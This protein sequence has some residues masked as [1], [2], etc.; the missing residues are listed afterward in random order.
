MSAAVAGVTT[1]PLKP[2]KTVVD[3]REG[4]IPG[5][6]L[7]KD[8]TCHNVISYKPNVLKTVICQRNSETSVEW[9]KGRIERPYQQ[10]TVPIAEIVSELDTVGMIRRMRKE[11]QPEPSQNSSDEG[12]VNSYA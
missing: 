3:W 11:N 12:L 1:L 10:N 4:E 5:L 2:V 9:S 7:R 6:Y 8:N